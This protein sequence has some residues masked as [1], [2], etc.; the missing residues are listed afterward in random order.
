MTLNLS[1]HLAATR[2]GLSV[3]DLTAKMIAKGYKVPETV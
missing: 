3:Q 2:L 1:S